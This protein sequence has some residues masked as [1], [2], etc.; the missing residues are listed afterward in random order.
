MK[1]PIRHIPILATALTAF[2]ACSDHDGSN[3]DN[4][5]L[6][7]DAMVYFNIDVAMS[8][9]HASR[10]LTSGIDAS[11]DGSES[12]SPDENLIHRAI[13]VIR[14]INHEG[15]NLLI[16][17]SNFSFSD[18]N[19]V[20]TLSAKIP[21]KDAI[22]FGKTADN[23]EYEIFIIANY[24]N[25]AYEELSG[26]N[27]C[28]EDFK[29]TVSGLDSHLLSTDNGLPMSNF[30]QQTVTITGW[31]EETFTNHISEDSA[32]PLLESPVVIER[33]VARIDYRDKQRDNITSDNIENTP[34]TYRIG[35][36]EYV[37]Q[38]SGMCPFNVS[39]EF[40][41]FRHIYEPADTEP[42]KF[43]GRES[44]SNYFLDTDN[45]VK[46]SD[47]TSLPDG[48]FIN[49]PYPENGWETVSDNTYLWKDGNRE[50]GGYTPWIYLP[51]NTIAD[52]DRQ[53]RGLTTGI[54]FRFRIISAPDNAPAGRQEGE[55]LDYYYFIRHNDNEDP[56]TMGPMEFGVVR[57]NIY[58]LSIE[59]V[60][61]FPE[62]YDPEEPDEPKDAEFE[63]KVAVNDWRQI[64][65]EYDY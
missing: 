12:G 4:G 57:N 24:D 9:I 30:Q 51:E 56:E 58:K 18:D 8:D 29:Y 23:R 42:V 44:E 48:H 43:L 40:F 54:I 15:D 45:D 34:H 50:H 62:P 38:L 11:S 52:A 22:R 3:R 27:F 25:S 49:P 41:I 33:S 13:L 39:R 53:I 55:Y 10:S 1:S 59:S 28:L 35:E 5:L 65:F 7:P 20:Y 19:S 36:S 46:F 31:N 47:I 2:A 17:V 16:P 61:S 21:L 32:F 60:S 37:I 64:R 14:A 63:V 26:G 6:A